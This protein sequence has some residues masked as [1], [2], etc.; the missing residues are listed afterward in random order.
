MWNIQYTKHYSSVE[1]KYFR[2]QLQ[3]KCPINFT[4]YYVLRSYSDVKATNKID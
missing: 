2:L 4:V 3:I 1:Y